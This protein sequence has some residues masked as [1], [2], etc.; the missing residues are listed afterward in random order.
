MIVWNAQYVLRCEAVLI[1][2]LPIGELDTNATIVIDVQ[3]L[4]LESNREYQK[5]IKKMTI[6]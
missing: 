6:F 5:S 1:T 4:R 3:I 2:E